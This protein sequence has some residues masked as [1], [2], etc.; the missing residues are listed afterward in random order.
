MEAIK[1]KCQKCGCVQMVGVNNPKAKTYTM[2]CPRCS[3]PEWA[4]GYNTEKELVRTWKR[5]D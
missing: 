5:I 3:S 4:P 1:I 2:Y